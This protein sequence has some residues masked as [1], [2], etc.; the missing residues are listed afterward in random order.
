MER[1]VVTTRRLFGLALVAWFCV[2]G[3]ARGQPATIV[4]IRHAEKPDDPADTGLTW[5]GK[6]RAAA[7]V[8]YFQGDPTVMAVMAKAGPPL[9]FAQATP[10]GKSQRPL[11]TLQPYAASFTPPLAIDQSVGSGHPEKLAHHLIADKD[12][13]FKGKTVL[14][15]WEHQHLAEM[16][17]DFVKEM[18]GRGITVKGAPAAWK[19]PGGQVYGRT[20]VFSFTDPKTC[21]FFDYGQQLMFDDAVPAPAKK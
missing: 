10:A 5:Q 16:G 11:L 19:W 1:I 9:L 17:Q 18:S 2:S 21:Q 15:C 3:S 6:A 12:G 20:W 8:A 14:I 13:T 4:M 7:L